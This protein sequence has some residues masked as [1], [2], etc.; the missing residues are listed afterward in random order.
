MKRFPEKK[1]NWASRHKTR[2]MRN[3]SV[4]GAQQWQVE[5]K[6]LCRRRRQKQPGSRSDTPGIST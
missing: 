2:Q 5:V 4:G 1:T 6:A 3:K